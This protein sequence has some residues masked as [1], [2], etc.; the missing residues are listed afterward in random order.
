MWR[1]ASLRIF[2]NEVYLCPFETIY[3]NYEGIIVGLATFLI[4]GIFHP[5]VIKAEYHFGKR[6]WWVFALAGVLF[7]ALSL[8]LDSTLWASI[9]GVTAFSSFWSIHELFEQENR[10]KKGWFPANPKRRKS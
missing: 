10:V 1:I 2:T 8:F 5:I 9:S 7:G 6:C 3:M 4:I